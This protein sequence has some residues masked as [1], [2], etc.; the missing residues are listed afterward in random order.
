MIGLFLLDMIGEFLLNMIGQFLLQVDH[1]IKCYSDFWCLMWG[2]FQICVW[3]Y[4]MCFELD[5][6]MILQ[7]LQR[8]R[9]TQKY[10]TIFRGT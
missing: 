7:L 6:H 5:G 8:E 2:V 10:D 1:H 9:H 3:N 4:R